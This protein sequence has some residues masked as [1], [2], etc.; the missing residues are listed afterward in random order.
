MCFFTTIDWTFKFTGSIGANL[1]DPKTIERE[2]LEAEMNGESYE[3]NYVS[4]DETTTYFARFFFD[5]IFNIILVF[6][7]LNMIQGIIIDTF[8]SLRENLAEKL[9]D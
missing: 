2:Q 7:L 8:G 5:N 4:Q 3:Y 6:I 1:Q 9:K